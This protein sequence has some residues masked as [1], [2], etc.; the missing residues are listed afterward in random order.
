MELRV[1]ASNKAEAA[2]LR[3]MLEE[4]LAQREDV[5]SYRYIESEGRGMT[6]VEIAVGFLIS[7]VGGVVAS[8]LEKAI[9]R[10]LA[11]KRRKGQQSGRPEEKEQRVEVTSL[12]G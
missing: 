1:V 9:D 12:D 4:V 5:E 11:K 6:G 7:V 10:E 3:E 2:E 8:K